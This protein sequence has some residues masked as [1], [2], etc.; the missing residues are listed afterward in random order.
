MGSD[1]L[2]HRTKIREKKDLAR[3]EAKKSPYETILII[4]EG[5]KTEVNYF[6]GLIKAH[7]LNTA[8]IEVIPSAKGSAPISIAEF[9]IQTSKNRDNIDKVYCVFDRDEHASFNSAV[10][11]IENHNKDNNKPICQAIVSSP[12]F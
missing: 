6:K 9:A 5:E 12:C 4:C 1:N 8:N 11:K 7:R 3:R 10:N 2:F